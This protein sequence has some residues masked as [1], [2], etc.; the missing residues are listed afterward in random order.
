MLHAR[1]VS[2][3]A[4]AKD[5][6]VSR[7]YS[8][9]TNGMVE[10]FNGRIASEVL[11]ITVASHADLETLLIAFNHAY[12]RRRQRVLDGLPPIGKVQQRLSAMPELASSTSPL[13]SDRQLMNKVDD[14]LFYANDVS[15]PDSDHSAAGRPLEVRGSA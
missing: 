13:S 9:Q 8:L 12:N 6:F 1:I 11:G 4:G 7:S 14:I 3:R 2:L 15:Q 5:G 10:R